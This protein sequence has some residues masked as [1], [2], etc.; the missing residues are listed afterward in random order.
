MRQPS[1]DR[2]TFLRGVGVALALP[3]LE[4][5]AA[6]D[7]AKP[8]AARKRFVCL[9]MGNGVNAGDW[10]AKGD[11]SAMELSKTLM[12][13]APFKE[14]L[15]VLQGL[16]NP[17]ALKGEQ[18][19]CAAPIIM[20]GGPANGGKIETAVSFDQVLA[21]QTGDRN[22]FPSLVLGIEGA[23][24]G[25]HGGWPL[26]YSGHISWSTA[27]TPIPRENNPRSLYDRL[28]GDPNAAR[29]SR[30][31]L[32][33]VRQDAK[34]LQP[35]LSSADRQRLDQYLTQL[36]E[37]EVRL[38]KAANATAKPVG[39]TVAGLMPNAPTK[40][41]IP[42][43]LHTRLMIDLIA[44]ALQAGKTDVAT[45]M[46][47]NDLSQMDCS[48]AGDN[49]SLRDHHGLSHVGGAQYQ[50]VNQYY[51]SRY[52]DLL[53]KLSAVREGESSLLDNSVVM[54]CS[55]LMQGGAHERQRLPI[56]LAGK[57]GGSLKTGRALSFPAGDNK[58]PDSAEKNDAR[59]LCNLYQSLLGHYGID[60]DRFGDSTGRLAGF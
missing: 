25:M 4:T 47:Q 6:A 36:R 49:P 41:P 2:R 59:R 50:L 33:L 24:L 57:A 18:H 56:V 23:N 39:P 32:D 12:P 3:W 37:I 52:A 1:F 31:V 46:F 60:S 34:G 48:F 15:N 22:D 45:L 5:L 27:T 20:S 29:E 44:V 58:S 28:V 17:N 30:S 42:T 35:G 8:A 53:G 21:A 19:I 54:F 26:I 7:P 38:D 13:L 40:D 51:V 43:D 55:S 14:S 10:W 11:G 9:Y 16:Y